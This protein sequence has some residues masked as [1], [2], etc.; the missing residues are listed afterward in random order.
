MHLL[1]F[2]ESIQLFPDGT[3]FIHVA[4][5]LIMIWILNRTLFRPVN[6]VLESREKAKGGK[7]GAAVSI[8]REAGEKEAKYNSELLDARSAGY[9]LIEKEQKKAVEAREKKLAAAN[10]EV[11]AAFNS[12]KAE[13]EK[14]TIKARAEIGAK[15]ETMADKIAAT[16]L[17]S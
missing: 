15:A 10:T 2:A 5:I 12:G 9:S 1:L 14:Q 17:N 6:R 11:A 4:L 13:L 8:L 3:L 16:I 7:G